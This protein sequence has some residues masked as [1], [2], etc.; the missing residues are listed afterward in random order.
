MIT[1]NSYCSSYGTLGTGRTGQH[2][3]LHFRVWFTYFSC[4][5]FQHLGLLRL[6]HRALMYNTCICFF[7]NTLK[8]TASFKACDPNLHDSP[9]EAELHADVADDADLRLR[10]LKFTSRNI[11]YPPSLWSNNYRYSN[12]DITISTHNVHRRQSSV[13]ESPQ[14]PCMI[15]QNC[16]SMS[17]R[18]HRRL[19]AR[20][21]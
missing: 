8:S 2:Q 11:Q 18:L 9:V 7:F 6:K 1:I 14:G 19:W 15:L 4:Q 21:P 17:I 16:W 5:S 10:W 3:E 12:N 20:S 13:P